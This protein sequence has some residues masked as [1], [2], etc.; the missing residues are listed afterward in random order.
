MAIKLKRLILGI[1]GNHEED[2]KQESKNLTFLNQ[3]KKEFY[4]GLLSLIWFN[5]ADKQCSNKQ[6]SPLYLV[7]DLNILNFI[8]K[9]VLQ[10]IFYNNI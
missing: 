2:P 5:H 6:I 8:F 10:F 7:L 4:N 3:I 9:I 1:S